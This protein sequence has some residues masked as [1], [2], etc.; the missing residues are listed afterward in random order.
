MNTEEHAPHLRGD[1]T[2]VTLPRAADIYA[3]AD[4]PRGP[5]VP[6]LAC[7]GQCNSPPRLEREEPCLDPCA[8]EPSMKVSAADAEEEGC[9]EG[10]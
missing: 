4:G 1:E 7:N 8:E 3:R 6:Q 5:R 9:G 10:V 2:G